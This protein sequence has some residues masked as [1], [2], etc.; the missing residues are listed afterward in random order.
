MRFDRKHVPGPDAG[1][2]GAGGE[3]STVT[4]TGSVWPDIEQ[5]YRTYDI[6]SRP[7]VIGYPRGWEDMFVA[8]N[9]VYN[10]GVTLTWGHGFDIGGADSYRSNFVANGGG[11]GIDSWNF[12]AFTTDGYWY[13]PSLYVDMGGKWQALTQWKGAPTFITASSIESSLGPRAKMDIGTIPA[14]SGSA[15]DTDYALRLMTTSSFLYTRIPNFYNGGYG[16]AAVVVFKY[17]DVTASFDIHS[18]GRPGDENSSSCLSVV[19]GNLRWAATS[20]QGFSEFSVSVKPDTWYIALAL[21]SQFG[22][23]NRVWLG[24]IPFWGGEQEIKS[25]SALGGYFNSHT[26]SYIGDCHFFGAS[27]TLRIAALYMGS[28]GPAGIGEL[29]APKVTGA[30]PTMQAALSAQARMRFKSTSAI[31]DSLTAFGTDLE[32]RYVDQKLIGLGTGALGRSFGVTTITTGSVPSWTN[33]H[34]GQNSAFVVPTLSSSDHEV[35]VLNAWR[36]GSQALETTAVPASASMYY[37]KNSKYSKIIVK[38]SASYFDTVAPAGYT[39]GTDD[40]FPPSQFVAGSGSL[41]TLISGS[42]GVDMSTPYAGGVLLFNV[43]VSG[44]LV[45]IKVWVELHH[46]SGSVPIMPL[47]SLGLGIKSPN[48]RWN[49]FGHPM[50]NFTDPS[51]GSSFSFGYAYSV[52]RDLFIL[53]EGAGA[54]MLDQRTYGIGPNHFGYS[55]VREKFPSWDRDLS[56]RTVFSDGAP[57]NNPRHN[58]RLGVGSGSYVGSPNAALGINNAWGMATTWTGSS[59]SPPDGWLTGPGGAAAVNEWSTTGSN[60]GASHIKPFYPLLDPIEVTIP[61]D[62]GFPQQFF[63]QQISPM[64]FVGQRPGLRGTEISGTWRMVF[65]TG[66]DDDGTS[67]YQM[68]LY[69]RQARLEITYEE[70]LPVSRIRMDSK[71]TPHFPGRRTVWQVSGSTLTSFVSSSNDVNVIDTVDS[72]IGRTFRIGLNTGSINQSSYALIYRLTGTLADLSGTTP[73]WLLNNEF[74]VPRIP[75]SSASLIEP[76]PEPVFSIHPQDLITVRPLLDGAQRLSDAARDAQPQQ[77]RAE[78]VIEINEEDDE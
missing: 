34:L 72:S 4:I 3:L 26:A 75:L 56:M 62:E 17:D 54:S 21:N 9:G 5:R 16:R 37:S 19:T 45:D 22:S 63:G 10:S 30:L 44:K 76:A 55:D 52:W 68:P 57:V 47:G 41:M 40:F 67:D 71:T 33:K 24:A 27:D 13:A 58:I 38:R 39:I 32:R 6:T 51:I 48:V 25:T 53:W 46:Q 1:F 78:Y 28:V 73:G 18:F 7:Q 42:G 60:R 65:W 14:V 2:L 66:N 29:V 20:S 12:T 43:P 74:G 8:S 49:G 69:F 35:R 23:D 31:D 77:T 61:F 64:S 50:L 70:H 59:G 11:A 36:S 15:A